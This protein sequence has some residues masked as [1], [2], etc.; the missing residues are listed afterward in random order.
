MHLHP[1]K[2]STFYGSDGMALRYSGKGVL[3]QNNLFEHNDWSIAIMTQ[4][5]GG[6]GTVI[7]NGH[8]DK[9]IRNTLR[10]NGASS[11]FRPSGSNPI[12][13]LNHIHHQCWG[14]LQHDGAGLDCS[15]KSV[16][17]LMLC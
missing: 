8:E 17:K 14:M 9:F 2:L 7:S 11:G 16:R 5:S 6:F 10:F 1:S 13:K 4:K 12:V 15:S 3:L